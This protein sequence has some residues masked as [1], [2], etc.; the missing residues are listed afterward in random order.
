[1]AVITPYMSPEQLAEALQFLATEHN[2]EILHKLAEC[3]R[4]IDDI[5]ECMG[6][7][8]HLAMEDLIKQAQQLGLIR[9][10][11]SETERRYALSEMIAVERDGLDYI[12]SVTLESDTT[13]RIR[14]RAI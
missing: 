4:T 5:C 11:P 3:S 14:T 1:M 9:E 2:R 6:D 13:I 7:V 8:D 10:V 12:L